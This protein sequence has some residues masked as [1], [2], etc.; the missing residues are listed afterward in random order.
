[1]LAPGVAYVANGRRHGF[2]AVPSNEMAHVGVNERRERCAFETE[3]VG[4]TDAT[5]WILLARSYSVS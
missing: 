3:P 2:I 5:P 4:A 1:M